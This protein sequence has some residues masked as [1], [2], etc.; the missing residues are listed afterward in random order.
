MNYSEVENVLIKSSY[1]K[2]IFN[3]N[4]NVTYLTSNFNIKNIGVSIEYKDTDEDFYLG[5]F[6]IEYYKTSKWNSGGTNYILMELYYKELEFC[7]TLYIDFRLNND[8]YTK[9]IRIKKY[10]NLYSKSAISKITNTIFEF[11]KLHFM[12]SAL[13]TYNLEN[14]E[15]ANLERKARGRRK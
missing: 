13:K 12:D 8:V 4:A 15:Y 6:V 10:E 7:N 1:F 2:E 5:D 11:E 3:Y 9:A 14:H